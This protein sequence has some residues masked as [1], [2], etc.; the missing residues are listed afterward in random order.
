MR[1][2][3]LSC[4]AV[5]CLSAPAWAQ[6]M[7]PAAEPAASGAAISDPAE[8][9]NRSMYAVNDVLDRAL[10]EPGAKAYRAATPGFFRAG[11]RNFLR[12]L[13][14]P[15]IFANDVLQGEIGRAGETAGR[16]GINSTLGVF[17]LVDVAD[18]MG[19]EHHDEDFGQTLAVW[20]VGSGPYLYLPVLGPSSVRDSAGMVVD[21]ALNPLTWAEFDGDDEFFAA[22][23]ALGALSTRE[24]LIEPIQ[25]VRDTSLD[26]YVTFRTTYSLT[27][28]SAIRNGL[29]DVQDLP[30]FEPT[31]SDDAVMEEQSP[32][33]TV[34]E[35]EQGITP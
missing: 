3:L 34:E 30:D 5:A 33:V 17:G 20:G 2:L 10:L 29:Q 11:V 26:P 32:P 12:N 19:I 4:V 25:S 18:D 35:G 8:G 14:A 9:F 7:E 1:A 24:G 22:R 6:D 27:R 16:F 21:M 28:E 31:L 13:R 15:V 23:G